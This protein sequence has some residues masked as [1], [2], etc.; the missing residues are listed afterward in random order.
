MY[1]SAQATSFAASDSSFLPTM[2]K[3]TASQA[4]EAAVKDFPIISFGDFDN[5]LFAVK[6]RGLSKDKLPVFVTSYNQQKLTLNLTPGKSWLKVKYP[7]EKAMNGDWNSNTQKVTLNV[8]EEMASVIK[9]VEE[10]VEKAVMEKLVAVDKEPYGRPKWRS[11]LWE[12]SFSAKLVLD[13][14][15]T[16]YLTQCRVRPF[17]KDVVVV[18]GKEQL[19][20]L[21]AENNYF[22]GAKAKVVVSPDSVWIIRKD[23]AAARVDGVSF[24]A[25]I[26]WKIHHFMADLQ[27]PVRYAVP[28]IFANASWSDEEE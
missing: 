23:P 9:G 19:E 10:T 28:D 27:E 17:N 11:A 22:Q 14:K 18:A 4:S 24:T 21:L 13:S 12:G 25:G 1:S 8:S 5:S 16:E 20:P 15:K 6:E 26:Y 2:A 3:R 7:I